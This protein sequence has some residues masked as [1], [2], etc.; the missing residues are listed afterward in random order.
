MFVLHRNRKLAM[1]ELKSGVIINYVSI[2]IRLA[3]Q[4]FI[5]PFVIASLGVEEYGLYMLSST[6]IVWLS[7]TDLGLAVTAKKYVTAYRERGEDDKQ[8]HFMGQSVMLFSVLG[9]VALSAGIV[10]Y[11]FLPDFFPKLTEAQLGTL[12]ILYLLTL[13]NL[14]LSFPLRPLACVPGAYLKFVVPGLMSLGASLINAGLTVLLLVC[15]YKSIGLTVMNVGLGV[16][17]LLV[18]LFYAVHFL[19]VRFKFSRPDWLLYRELLMFSIWIL[20]AQLLDLFYWKAGAPIVARLVGS[21]AVSLFTLSTS[22]ACYFTTAA[23]AI[24]GVLAPKL[25][26]MVAGGSSDEELTTAMIRIGRM[27]LAL[28]TVMTLGFIVLGQDFLRLWVGDSI[29]EGVWTVWVGALV[30]QIPLLVPLTQNVGFS[31]LQ[32]KSIHR[33]NTINMFYTSV[34]C[35]VTGYVLTL[36]CGVLGMLIGTG[37][38]F[39]LGQGVL[40]NVYYHRKAGLNIPRFIKATYL[41]VLLPFV[42]LLMVGWAW[43][44]VYPIESWFNFFISASVYGAVSSLML[45]FIFLNRGERGLLL[46]PLKCILSR[47]PSSQSF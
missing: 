14:I 1:S 13:A 2:F 5:T 35:V 36:H 25:M 9:A 31:I 42:I 26:R 18:N 10:C 11:F 30:I 38:A 19:G 41:P 43:V 8:A 44:C 24:S 12:D 29:G 34:L 40:L 28:L 15:G 3:T 4:F 32:A 6:V 16:I 39:F 7:L 17:L 27:Q 46:E 21:E 33:G 20:L 45:F 37:A 22:F 23:T 47:K